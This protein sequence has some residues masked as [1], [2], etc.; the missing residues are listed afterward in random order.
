[1]ELIT[2]NDLVTVKRYIVASANSFIV[3]FEIDDFYE[4]LEIMDTSIGLGNYL[5][6]VNE[7]QQGQEILKIPD[8]VELTYL[9]QTENGFFFV[10][11]VD[12]WNYNVWEF[13]N[14]NK[15]YTLQPISV[16]S[17]QEPVQVL[18]DGSVVL[19][20][21]NFSV[22]FYIWRNGVNHR[23]FADHFHLSWMVDDYQI[24]ESPGHIF[25]LSDRRGTGSNPDGIFLSRFENQAHSLEIEKQ[26]QNINYIHNFNF[27]N[28]GSLSSSIPGSGIL[29]STDNGET[30]TFKDYFSSI[31]GSRNYVIPFED[32]VHLLYVADS[33]VYYSESW[34]DN[35]Q[36]VHTLIDGNSMNYSINGSNVLLYSI[37]DVLVSGDF[38]KTWI[39]YDFKGRP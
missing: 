5:I 29:T 19:T 27:H 39:S 22:T 30:W 25:I 3:H 23:L 37:D 1:M 35:W 32:K 36:H 17:Y 31:A 7:K 34:G 12:N 28:D 15:D 4:Q 33:K 26:V 6:W 11:N 13:S 16:S 18:I 8:G 14:Y 20:N 2:F 21:E 9:N 24:T 38:G 10:E